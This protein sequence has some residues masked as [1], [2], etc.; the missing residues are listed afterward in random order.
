MF[1]MDGRVRYSE[2]GADGRIRLDAIVN[3]LQDC[4]MLHSEGVGRGVYRDA[5]LGGFWLMASWQIEILRAPRYHEEIKIGTNPYEFRGVFGGRNVQILDAEGAQLVRANS[6]WV[7]V[8]SDTGAP[9][10]VPKDEAEAYTHFADRIDM[11][12]M[13]RKITLPD[14]MRECAPIPVTQDLIDTNRHV[15]NCGYV[16]VAMEAAEYY[17]LPKTL[18]VEYKQAAVMGND[19]C[20]EIYRDESHCVVELHGRDK[21]PFAVVEFIF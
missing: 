12:Y 20:P 10:R 17:G 1:T 3:Y 4:V 7:Y 6:I 13:P 9:A 14:G 16:R 8:N 11:E 18:R 2:V 21:T 15:N 19:F 5:S